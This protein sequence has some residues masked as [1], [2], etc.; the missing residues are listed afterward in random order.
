MYFIDHY[1]TIKK[2]MKELFDHSVLII[3][4][5][6][7]VPVAKEHSAGW[8]IFNSLEGGGAMGKIKA[9]LIVSHYLICG[10]GFGFDE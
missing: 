4:I 1:E 5:F 8:L 3:I 2:R 7:V 10:S 6:V 9:F